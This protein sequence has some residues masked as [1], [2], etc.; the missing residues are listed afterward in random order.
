MT[1]SKVLM[2]VQANLSEDVG[3]KTTFFL[4]LFYRVLSTL[5][6]HKINREP[7]IKEKKQ[8]KTNQ[9]KTYET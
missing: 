4:S 8:Q 2:R 1:E 3:D 7:N 9:Y 6:Q 5:I